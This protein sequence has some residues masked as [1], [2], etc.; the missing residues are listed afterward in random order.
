MLLIFS[1]TAGKLA[2]SPETK[3]RLGYLFVVVFVIVGL[4]GALEFDNPF[5]PTVMA[6]PAVFMML[7]PIT[8]L[9]SKA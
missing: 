2:R 1:S 5:G 3:V 9:L 7:L 8:E 4:Y 6:T